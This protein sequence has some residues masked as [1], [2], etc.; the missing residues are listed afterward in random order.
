M[1]MM[2]MIMIM[3][4]AAAAAAN[5]DDG[6]LA[7]SPKWRSGERLRYLLVSSFALIVKLSL[8]VIQSC[9]SVQYIALIC[10]ASTPVLTET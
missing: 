1:M 2:V 5:D 9:N 3:M 4:G 8:F 7:G 10:S 6:G